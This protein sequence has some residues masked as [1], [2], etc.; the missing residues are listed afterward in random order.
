MEISCRTQHNCLA[1][2]HR[3]LLVCPLPGKLHG[4]LDRLCP[5]VHGEYHVVLEDGRDLFGELPKDGVIE[6]SGGEGEPLG[7]IN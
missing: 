1:L 3:L 7:L 4:S 6:G 5:R 2:L